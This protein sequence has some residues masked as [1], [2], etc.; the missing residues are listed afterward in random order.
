M[1]GRRQRIRKAE[2]R[3]RH[4]AAD[5]MRERETDRAR[6]AMNRGH[7]ILRLPNFPASYDVPGG[8]L[9]PQASLVVPT[10]RC[11]PSRSLK[12]PSRHWPSNTSPLGEV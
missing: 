5:T 6:N 7:S 9:K 3:R 2:V 4:G 8:Y 11:L 12:Q 1:F 10:N